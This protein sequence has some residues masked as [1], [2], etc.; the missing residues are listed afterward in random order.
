M[1]DTVF[2]CMIHGWRSTYQTCPFCMCDVLKS[3]VERY[4]LE[5]NGLR[6]R[7]QEI[8]NV[9]IDKTCGE[10]SCDECNDRFS[11]QKLRIKDLETKNKHL[12]MELK[13]LEDKFIEELYESYVIDNNEAIDHIRHIIGKYGE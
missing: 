13:N 2:E 8:D 6:K 9:D 1:S 11:V 10:L 7:L 5:N 4:K 3:D 12:V